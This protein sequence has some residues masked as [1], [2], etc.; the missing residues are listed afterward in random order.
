MCQVVMYREV[1]KESTKG[2][3]DR[4]RQVIS[5]QLS[6]YIMDKFVKD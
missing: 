3:G 5:S 6:L 1:R 4:E 2:G